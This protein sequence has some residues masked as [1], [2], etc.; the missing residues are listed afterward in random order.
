MLSQ[1][2]RAAI[3]RR[4]GALSRG[5]KT[6]AGKARSCRNAITH[7][8]RATTLAAFV[9]PESALL[10]A[11]D[12]QAFF[13]LHEQNL[14]KY[15]PAD[16]AEAAV[17]REIS[18]LQWANYR[19]ATARQAHLNRELELHHA[20][21]VAYEFAL[22]LKSMTTLRHEY[23]ANARLIAQAERRLRD[24]Q[25]TWPA[26]E[27]VSLSEGTEPEPAQPVENTEPSPIRTINYSGPL[28]RTVLAVYKR[29]F[30]VQTLSF[31][32]SGLRKA[33]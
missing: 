32:E 23:T 24:L 8:R 2:E 7:G 6:D 1:P 33:M 3:A 30:P 12:R 4:N 15:R 20:I 19:I 13:R 17:V 11:E 28:T 29:L 31:V 21:E 26:A 16:H 5:P 25:A 14:A 18:D 9:P 22:N 10:R 27:P